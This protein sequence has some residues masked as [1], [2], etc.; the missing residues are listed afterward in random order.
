MANKPIDSEYLKNNL[1]LFKEQ[2][3]DPEIDDIKRDGGAWIGTKAEWEALSEE[4]KNKWIGKEVIIIDDTPGGEGSSIINDAVA[5]LSSTYSSKYL[6]A[7]KYPTENETLTN[8]WLV[9]THNPKGDYNKPRPVTGSAKYAPI[10]LDKGVRYVTFLGDSFIRCDI[11][12][13]STRGSY[14]R[15]W[16]SMYS[17]TQW[18]KWKEEDGTYTIMGS[19]S[20][21]Y[22]DLTIEEIQNLLQPFSVSMYNGTGK[23]RILAKGGSAGHWSFDNVS[24]YVIFEELSWYVATTRRRLRYSNGTWELIG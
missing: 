15:H 11:Y 2:I 6:D 13:I 5:S 1:K 17:G 16:S 8:A 14:N 24:D 20:K 9:D 10:D 3:I 18:S 7:Y 23:V 12:G 21:A 22:P 19:E 4:E